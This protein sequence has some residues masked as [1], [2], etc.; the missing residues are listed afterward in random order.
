MLALALLLTAAV[1]QFAVCATAV[2]VTCVHDGDSLW[3]NGERIRIADID[4]PELTSQCRA[5]RRLALRARDRLVVLLNAGA[6]ALEPAKRNRDRHGRLLRVVVRDGRSLGDQ[7]VG[8]GLA[9][10]WTGRRSPWCA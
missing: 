10:P 7:L 3:L 2:R 1:P 4:T 8:E 6:F 5:E 9:R